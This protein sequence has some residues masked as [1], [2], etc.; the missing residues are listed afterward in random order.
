MGTRGAAGKT[1]AHRQL[2][3]DEVGYLGYQ[4]SSDVNT[5]LD[6]GTNPRWKIGCFV[7]DKRFLLLKH[8]RLCPRPVL[9]PRF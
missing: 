4:A 2:D 5:P 1:S 9:P 8:N 6:G 7:R 3:S